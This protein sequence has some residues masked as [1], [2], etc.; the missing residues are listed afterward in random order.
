MERPGLFELI[1][2][3]AL[4]SVAYLL[5]RFGV[6]CGFDKGPL[7][8]LLVLGIFGFLLVIDDIAVGYDLSLISISLMLPFAGYMLGTAAHKKETKKK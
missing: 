6:A 5:Y 2:C 1:V 4:F 8:I 3:L 7:P